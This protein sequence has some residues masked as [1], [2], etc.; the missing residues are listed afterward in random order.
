MKDLPFIIFVSS[1]FNLYWIKLH[2]SVSY[3]LYDILF[4][5][6][7]HFIYMAQLCNN[8]Q[9]TY[10]QRLCDITLFENDFIKPNNLW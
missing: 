2:M 5:F 10:I 8:V 4:T 6:T 1:P 9:Y 3:V 7:F